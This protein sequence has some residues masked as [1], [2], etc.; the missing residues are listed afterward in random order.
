MAINLQVESPAFDRI[1][2]GDPV[3]IEDGVRL[4][5]FALNNLYRTEGQDFLAASRTMKPYVKSDAPAAGQDNYD[6]GDASI[7]LFTGGTAFNLT[8]IRNGLQGRIVIVFNLGTATV[9]MKHEV[10]S[11]AANRIDMA[12]AADKGVA[13]LKGMILIY[14]NARWRELS[15]A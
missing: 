13:T 7:L 2:K 8:G 14:L 15:L 12:G 10:T 6:V 11:D 5:W 3:A 4:V 9:T 1:R